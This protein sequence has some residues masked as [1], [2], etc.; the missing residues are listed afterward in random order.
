MNDNPLNLDLMRSLYRSV[1]NKG[2]FLEST[3]IT[4]SALHYVLEGRNMP[5][6]KTIASFAN[7]FGIPCGMLF[8]DYEKYHSIGGFA[9]NMKKYNKSLA[10][11]DAVIFYND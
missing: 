6:V 11:S 3:G 7:Y 1:G 8:S 5:S 9:E 4:K 2:Q 10:L